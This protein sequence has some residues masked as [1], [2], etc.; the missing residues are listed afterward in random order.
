MHIYICINIWFQVSFV[1]LKLLNIRGNIYYQKINIQNSN[2]IKKEF[3]IHLNEA[4]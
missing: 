2:G 4:L 1:L 3:K